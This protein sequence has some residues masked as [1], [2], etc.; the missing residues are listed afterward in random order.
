MDG[1]AVPAAGHGSPLCGR[2][3]RGSIRRPRLPPACSPLSRHRPRW[4]DRGTL[5]TVSSTRA[6]P[7]LRLDIF[8]SGVR[9]KDQTGLFSLRIKKTTKVQD[10]L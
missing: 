9:E 2:Q 7:N 8:L 1:L 5:G 3:T 4:Y 6:L 10:D